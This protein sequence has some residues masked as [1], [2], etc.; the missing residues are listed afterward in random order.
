LLK[1][2]PQV[3]DWIVLY[4]SLMRGLG[5]MDELGISDRLRYVG[6]CTVTGELFDLGC[7]P[8]MR[9]GDGR[10]IAELHAL[11]DVEVIQVLDEFEGY[12]A[13]RPR[14]SLYLR[15]SVALVS[16]PGVEAWVYTCN[17][18]PDASMRIISGDWRA[19][20]IERANE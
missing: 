12:S 6:P 4:G 7:F 20:L 9:H 18:V 3:G 15:E 11:L 1:S 2:E 13:A 16:P 19:H 14:E 8:G 10:V 5:A 17:Q